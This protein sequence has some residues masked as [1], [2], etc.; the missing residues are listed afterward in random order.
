MGTDQTF[1][2]VGAGLA[3]AKAAQALRDEGFAGRVILLGEES[4]RPYERPPLSKGYLLGRQ[5]RTDCA[6]TVVAPTLTPLHAAL[7][8]EMGG[9]FADLHRRHGVEFLLGSGVTGI[10]GDGRVS[11]VVTTD[12]RLAADAVVIGIGVHPN[13]DPAEQAGLTLDHGGD[14]GIV[15]DARLRT[16]DPDIYAAGDVASG[17]SSRYGRRIRVEHWAN[18]I[19]GGR[20]AARAM[21]GQ[22]VTYDDLPYFF[23]DQYDVG[24]EFAGWFAP[25]GY[26]RVITR[27]DVAGHAFHAF[28]LSANRIVAGMHV[29]LWDEGIGAVQELIRGRRP[30]DPVRLADGSI[31]LAAHIDGRPA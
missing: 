30:I 19:G 31:P 21:L 7:G 1:V 17:P 3:G 29:N 20:A 25:G 2:I 16:D 11:A 6:V 22:D 10:Q 23:S 15:V 12:G 5:D 18:A 13:T 14:R 24:M 28:W 4:E 27:G 26:D 8:P 9:F